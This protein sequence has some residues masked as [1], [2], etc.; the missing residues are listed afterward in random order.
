[1]DFI[2][3][4]E[5]DFND[6][7]GKNIN[8]LKFAMMVAVVGRHNIM[9]IGE[10]GCGKSAMLKKF[11]MIMPKLNTEEAITV[12]RLYDLANIPLHDLDKLIRPFRVPHQTI[13]LVEMCGGGATLKPGEISLAHGGM[14][15]LD[16]ATEFKSSVLQMLRVPLE[17]GQIT[18]CRA[19]ETTVYPSNFQLAMAINPCPCGCYGQSD[20]VCLCSLRSIESYWKKL[21]N[22][23]L[24]RID[25]RIDMNSTYTIRQ[26][27]NDN[28]LS[29]KQIRKTIEKA[30]TIQY[31]RQGKLNGSLSPNE[32][33]M[34]CPLSE[35]ALK[36][37]DDFGIVTNI[38]A[39]GRIS[40]IKMAR[41]FADID[42]SDKIDSNHMSLA[43]ALRGET[44][45]GY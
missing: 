21:G 35:D 30:Q 19:N 8:A 14:L 24:D 7:K 33:E 9:A 10:P 34:Y 43:L 36:H 2:D 17:S 6:I 15:F 37:L 40:L 12:N 38:S 4:K 1:M 25:I 32:I 23:L 22:P 5:E 16:E 18:L 29:L 39:R 44:P 41:T 26:L 31:N 27:L 3:A 20:K 28:E 13:P 42:E 45:I 11:P